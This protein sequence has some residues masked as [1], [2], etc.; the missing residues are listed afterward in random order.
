M[1]P[2]KIIAAGAL[3]ALMVALLFLDQQREAKLE[4]QRRMAERLLPFEKEAITRLEINRIQGRIVLERNGEGWTLREP[5]ETPAD[6]QSLNEMLQALDRQQRVGAQ[7]ASAEQMKSFGLEQ[8]PIRV[9]V[10]STDGVTTDFVVGEDSP[11]IGEAYAAYSGE[12]EYF[13]VSGVL[14]RNLARDV[15]SIRDKNLIAFNANET[16]TV[17]LILRGEST[18]R[19]VRR[20][21][22]WWLDEPI[23]AP[24][25][26]K[27]IGSLLHAVHLT[28]AQNFIDTD[29]LQ[30]ARYG[31]DVPTVV[32]HFEAA[33]KSGPRSST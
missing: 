24:A 14:K 16:T 4:R 26:E 2:S 15:D 3:F 31:L 29:T 32:A 25:D 18:I 13:T 17:T 30:L 10:R 20:D 1:S 28:K 33:G 5:L 9:A 27:A 19:A 6:S 7:P 23:E 21:T 8:A 22:E 11:V 12:D